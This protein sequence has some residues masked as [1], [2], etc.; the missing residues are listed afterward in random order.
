LEFFPE[1]FHFSTQLKSIFI[2]IFL[3]DVFVPKCTI[4]LKFLWKIIVKILPNISNTNKK[5]TMYPS[6]FKSLRTFANKRISVPQ[7]VFFE[8]PPCH[9]LASQNEKCWAILCIIK[10]GKHPPYQRITEFRSKTEIQNFIFLGAGWPPLPMSIQRKFLA[11]AGFVKYFNLFKCVNKSDPE[12]L[13]YK[14]LLFS[15]IISK[16]FQ[17]NDLLL[18]YRLNI[19]WKL[20]SM[21]FMN[22]ANEIFAMNSFSG[23]VS[24]YSECTRVQ[25][26]KISD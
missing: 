6:Q 11:F 20:E 7:L 23:W 16:V 25:K 4:Y 5:L 19:N 13:K 18:I 22:N 12:N 9:E 15:R 17:I 1:N 24:L 14:Y 10:R 8:N 21:H 26:L 2:R 3:K